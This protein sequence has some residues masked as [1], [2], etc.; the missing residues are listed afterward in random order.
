MKENRKIWFILTLK[1]TISFQ[2]YR[3]CFGEYTG[4]RIFVD[5]AFTSLMRKMYLPNTEFIFNLGD[6]PL[7]KKGYDIIPI[8]GWCGS[9]G[10][11]LMHLV[12]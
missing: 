7:V 3:R 1:S 4:F 12:R 10:E 5:A 2:L 11:M 9:K 8:I 6:W